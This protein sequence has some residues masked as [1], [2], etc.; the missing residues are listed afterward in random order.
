MS[1]IEK[2]FTKHGHYPTARFGRKPRRL[3]VQAANGYLALQIGASGWFY[4]PRSDAITLINWTA[5]MVRAMD[6]EFDVEEAIQAQS[7]LEREWLQDLRQQKIERYGRRSSRPTR[8]A[9]AR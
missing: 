6:R 8:R 1:L 3:H 4:L 5:K 2:Y 9:R 7:D